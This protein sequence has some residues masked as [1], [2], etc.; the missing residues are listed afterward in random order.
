MTTSK[1]MPEPPG[2]STWFQEFLKSE[3][4]PYPGRGTI[5]A[6][7]V[8]AATITMLLIMTFRIHGGA[9]GA[10]YAFLISRENLRS[11]Y[12]SG[13][14]IAISYAA[15]LMFV[16]CGADI[17]ADQ[18]SA[19]ILWFVCSMF[20]TFF[21]LR[22]L[23]HTD[24]ATGFAVLVVNALPIWQLPQSA[25]YR[26]ELTLWQTLA[27]GIGTVVT[28]SV[29]VIFHSFRPRDEIVEGLKE[30]LE[31]MQI[32]FSHYAVEKRVPDE[33][34]DRVARYSMVG[35]SGLRRDLA[36]SNYGSATAD[37]WSTTISLVGRVVDIGAGLIATGHPLSKGDQE[38]AREIEDQLRRIILSLDEKKD[39]FHHSEVPVKQTA[40]H[41]DISQ[42]AELRR[43]L[44][45]LE[46]VLSGSHLVAKLPARD[47]TGDEYSVEDATD[48]NSQ[49][50]MFVPDAFRNRDH[51]MFAVRGCLAA[52]L[53]YLIYELLEWRGIATSVT[54][55]VV[56]ALSTAGASRQKQILRVGGAIAGGLI[57]G[58]GSQVFVLPN[59]DS[60]VSFSILF[61]VATALGAWIATSSSR[62]SYF[63]VQ[64]ALAFYLINLQ[65]FTIQ[66]SLSVARD[67][68]VGIL[69]GLSMM[70]LVFDGIGG[71]TAADAMMHA[72]CQNLR[73]MAKM[74]QQTDEA[75]LSDATQHVR[76]L[77]EQI[78]SYF[79]TVN[80]QADGIPFEFGLRRERGMV[81][82]S[83]IRR[84]QPSLR[85]MYFLESATLQNR[86][87]E[88]GEALPATFWTAIGSM[89]CRCS[90]LLTLMADRLEGKPVS[91]IQNHLLDQEVPQLY[92]SLPAMML[93][94]IQLKRAR[95]V[96]D[97]SRKTCD[98]LTAIAEEVFDTPSFVESSLKR[99]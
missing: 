5:V 89:H 29:E 53:C 78:R 37:S 12:R 99:F 17:F 68:V 69:L 22:T 76:T 21:A 95:N 91:P 10:L 75:S 72:F 36:R 86:L 24:V 92:E 32:L 28:I 79:D 18:Q 26:V 15:G 56:T 81:W 48:E 45:M 87:F 64:L 52:T 59:I 3:L 54:T 94:S 16:L 27:V 58:M 8:V 46:Q 73:A 62:L 38:Q 9:L 39:G 66:T 49:L 90:D 96:I 71:T 33:I 6:R 74:F 50:S 34:V 85:T 2:F 13:V 7:M 25:E 98:E 11:T 80:A 93:T 70:W 44:S 97:L 42:L 40:P 4:A 88:E 65:E 20:V 47:G 57:L 31:A 30:R 84:W 63:G 41:S 1:S 19:R 77:R 43:S 61:A 51:L 82:R 67:R 55:C 14:A 23:R 35:T 83:L 60:I